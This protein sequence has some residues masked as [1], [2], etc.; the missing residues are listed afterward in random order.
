MT[1]RSVA[2]ERID[3]RSWLT[4]NALLQALAVFALAFA[5]R[6]VFAA[7]LPP[8]VDELY[9]LMAA[10]SWVSDGSLAVW[11]GE[12][13]RTRYFTV[14]V[15]A[16][17]DLAGSE[18]LLTARLPS[19][20]F[21]SLLV[22]GVFLW[23][24]REA[25]SVAA[26]AS[27]LMLCLSGLSLT[28][29][30]YL[31]F[32]VLQAL[33]LWTAGVL[34]YE[35]V[36]RTPRGAKLGLLLVAAI[37]CLL[38]AVYLQI[39]TMIGILGLALWSAIAL[40]FHPPIRRRL[41][42]RRVLLALALAAAA[43]AVALA[44]T[45][46]RD[47]V[48]SLYDRFRYAP[49]WAES[50]KSDVTY[51]YRLLNDRMTLLW[52]LAP[53]AALLALLRAPRAASYCLVMSVTIL[54]FH[55]LGAMKKADYIAYIMIFLLPVFGIAFAAVLPGLLRLAEE[56]SVRFGLARTRLARPIVFLFVVGAVGFASLGNDV[57]KATG[58]A[59]AKGAQAAVFGGKVPQREWLQ[60]VPTVNEPWD[61]HLPQLRRLVAEN[62]V[63]LVTDEMRALYYIGRY[64]I[65]VNRSRL[66]EYAPDED[67]A[68]DPRTGGPTIASAAALDAVIDCWP[69]GL[70]VTG[71][72]TF[73]TRSMVPEA[74]AG[75]FETRTERV[76]LE[77]DDKEVIAFRWR[78]ADWRP[79]PACA[80]VR[81]ASQP[82]RPGTNG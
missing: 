54:V 12:Y 3:R 71:L 45:G 10:R 39:M 50:R 80:A 63:F 31:R 57:F 24:R 1:S 25:G 20:I 38:G 72:G 79:G 26:W 41:A 60:V 53:V 18:S 6:L 70:L 21:G 34:I 14:L 65:L 4:A 59:L 42:D 37:V 56:A 5:V 44:A 2:I 27:A 58:V 55:S 77:A 51:Y 43:F 69:S 22:S 32:Y 29:D 15:G 68:R 74:V 36:V 11:H 67:F 64:D 73:E 49:L 35:V 30:Q 47:F 23:V 61:E 52:H 78:H 28:I 7:N 48:E 13:T 62:D 75:V 82:A 8:R 81:R 16:F 46:L 66:S 19:V 17:L 76:A 40:S 9:H 33:L